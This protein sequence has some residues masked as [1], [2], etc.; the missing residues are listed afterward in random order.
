M[1]KNPHSRILK[2]EPKEQPLNT[3]PK[4]YSIYKKKRVHVPL[5]YSLGLVIFY[6]LFSINGGNLI[7]SLLG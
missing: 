1:R 4:S 6:F 7:E 2:R 3:V 5:W